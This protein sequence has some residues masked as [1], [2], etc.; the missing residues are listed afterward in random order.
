MNDQERLIYTF[1]YNSPNTTE[2]VQAAEEL[3]CN[4]HRFPDTVLFALEPTF[5]NVDEKKDSLIREWGAERFFELYKAYATVCG[6]ASTVVSGAEEHK[7]L[8]KWSKE[9][10]Q[11]IQIR[12]FAVAAYASLMENAYESAEFNEMKKLYNQFREEYISL[13][14]FITEDLHEWNIRNYLIESLSCYVQSIFDIKNAENNFLI[15]RKKYLSEPDGLFHFYED[16]ARFARTLYVKDLDKAIYY[17]EDAIKIMNSKET[18]ADRKQIKILN[19]QKTYLNMVKNDDAHLINDLVIQYKAF[20]EGFQEMQR[21]IR[22]ALIMVCLK[23]NNVSLADDLFREEIETPQPRNK[24][25]EI[26]YWQARALK[27]LVT[28]NLTYAAKC[29]KIAAN[30]AQGIPTFLHI[31]NHNLK[32]LTSNPSPIECRFAVTEN[33]Q[34]GIYYIDTRAAY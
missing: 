25:L 11:S 32:V 13:S 9:Y 16:T 29:L 2:W 4:R 18:H 19:F 17:T 27:S 23:Y 30:K 28:N 6:Y 14:P 33:L 31:I 34:D 20:S 22:L 15:H 1:T 26:F 7:K 12:R 24:R 21:K 10:P 3:Y 5:C 8:I